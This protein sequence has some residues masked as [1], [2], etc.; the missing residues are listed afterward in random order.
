MK[1]TLKDLVLLIQVNL[2]ES[3]PSENN[4]N[5]PHSIDPRWQ[6]ENFVIEATTIYGLS[7]QGVEN[8]KK[9]GDLVLPNVNKEAN[10]LLILPVLPF[11][12]KN[13]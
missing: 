13:L 10:I 5:I 1:K 8:L 9:D 11:I 3:T 6:L 7:E 12:L 2:F 4:T